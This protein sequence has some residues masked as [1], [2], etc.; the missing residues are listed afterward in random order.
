[1]KTRE[2]IERL[3]QQILPQYEMGIFLNRNV[4]MNIVMCM[5]L[6]HKEY[7]VSKVTANIAVPHDCT[8]VNIVKLLHSSDGH[9]FSLC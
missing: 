3:K 7:N 1:M 9:N 6:H 8:C 2:T 4:L 5:Y